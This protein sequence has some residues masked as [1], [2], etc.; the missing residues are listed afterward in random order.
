MIKNILT[1]Q[2]KDLVSEET[3]IVIEEAFQQA[4]ETKVNEKLQA[5]K[6]KIEEGRTS[7]ILSFPSNDIGSLAIVNISSFLA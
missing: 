2:F 1:E 4:V 6:D 5:E 3:L 7:S